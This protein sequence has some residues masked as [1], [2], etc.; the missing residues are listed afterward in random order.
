VDVGEPISFQPAVMEGQ[1]YVATDKGSLF[2][3]DA[4][5]PN[6]TGWAMWGGN[7]QHNGWITPQ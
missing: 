7:A 4:L 6:A 3:L 2:K 1:L 5:N